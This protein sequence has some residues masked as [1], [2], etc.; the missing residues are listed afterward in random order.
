MHIDG[1]L[2]ELKGEAQTKQQEASDNE[3]GKNGRS[4]KER[5]QA[6]REWKE[7]PQANEQEGRHRKGKESQ[8][9]KTHEKRG[10]R[11]TNKLKHTGV[12]W[13]KAISKVKE[14]KEMKK[15]QPTAGDDAKQL[16]SEMEADKQRK[17]GNARS[18]KAMQE[19]EKQKQQNER[20]GWT[21]YE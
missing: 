17:Q 13:A 20:W 11:S 21:K 8:T 9:K 5:S 4:T 18:T 10:K 12:D 7:A 15:K 3:Q 14:Q 1:G 6:R 16:T 2:N 19:E